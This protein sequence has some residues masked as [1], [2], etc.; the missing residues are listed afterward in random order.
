MGAVGV[1]NVDRES[2]L[3]QIAKLTSSSVLNGSESLCNL[4]RF[5]AKQTLDHP[6]SAVKE[7]H[8]ATEVLGRTTDFDPR[9]DSAV[10]VQTG[11]LRSKLAEYY[12][13]EGIADPVFVKIPRGSYHLAFHN[14]QPEPTPVFKR[15]DTPTSHRSPRQSMTIV[16]VSLV[17]AVGTLAV[18]FALR[19]AFSHGSAGESADAIEALWVRFFEGS[20]PPLVVYSNA[21]F[22]GRPETGLRYFNSATDSNTDTNSVILDH[23]TG[24]GEVMAIHELD[25]LFATWHRAMRLKRGRLLTWDDAKASNVVFIGSPSENLSL[26]EMPGTQDFIFKVAS[27]G[28]RKGDLSI[29]NVHPRPGEASTYFPSQALPIRE[30]YAV[31]SLVPGLTNTQHALVLA[32]LTTLGTQAAAEF[33]C[34]PERLEELLSVLGARSKRP[35]PQFEAV[36]RVRVSGGVPVQ[37]D[38]VTVHRP[39]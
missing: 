2:K 28:P 8:I 10:R 9:L 37:S 7:Y 4:L 11:R 13:N 30:D 16:L 32:G 35:F 5:L 20:E 24:V 26:R 31:V 14:R 33:V 19:S 34:R 18:D 17:A 36:L 1:N 15:A 22:V 23:Y 25:Q 3:G 38:L 21:A 39:R 27:E 12:A 29:V 6:G